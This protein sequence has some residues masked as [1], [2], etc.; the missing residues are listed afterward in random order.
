MGY[1]RWGGAL[2]RCIPLCWGCFGVSATIAAF[3]GPPCVHYMFLIPGICEVLQECGDTAEA[4]S[5]RKCGGG[6]KLLV[7]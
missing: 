3:S 1:S 4:V 6:A 7:C 2:S 5:V